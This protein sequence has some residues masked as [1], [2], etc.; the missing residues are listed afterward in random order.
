[1]ILQKFI[2]SYKYLNYVS[3]NAQV[4]WSVNYLKKIAKKNKI[5]V[6]LNKL[7]K[8]LK[9]DYIYLFDDIEKL[10]STFNVTANLPLS[11]EAFAILPHGNNIII[12]ANDYRGFVY[13]ITEIV[14]IIKYSENNNL[15]I[16]TQII[17]KPTTKIRSISKCFESIDEDKEWFYNKNS[18]DEYLTLLISERFNR[19]TLTLG[20]QYN[21]P[22]GN[23]FIKDVYLYL[24]YP[25]IVSP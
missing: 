7:N 22:Y 4:L 12:Y 8:D 13:A 5:Q 11:T 24:P 25:F 14:D 2:V 19:F 6:K 18:W 9:S 23:E 3:F 15:I 10:K 21:Y 1:M 17:E 20:M 16:K